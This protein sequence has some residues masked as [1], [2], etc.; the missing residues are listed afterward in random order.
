MND[1]VPTINVLSPLTGETVGT[2]KAMTHEE[3][4]QA[5][6]NAY[7]AF[8]SWK[9]KTILERA[10]IISKAGDILEQKRDQIAASLEQEIGK[11]IETAEKEVDRSIEYLRISV[12]EAKKLKDEVLQGD[13]FKGIKPG[14]KTALI[15]R[16]PV[17][18]VLAISPFNYPVNLAITKI[19]PALL[20]GNSVVFKP[21]TQG[22]LAASMMV[23]A[24]TEAGLPSSLL[25]LITGKSSEIGD[26][27]VTQPT[28]S[29]IAFTGSPKVG[30]RIVELTKGR[31]PLLMEMGGKDP[32]IILSD[33]DLELAS[34]EVV[35]GAFS[36]AGQRCTA[37]KMV[38]VEAP[39]AQEFINKVVEKAKAFTVGPVISVEQKD[40]LL[41]LIEDAKQKGANVA[42]EGSVNGNVLSPTILTNVATTAG[43]FHEEQFGPVLP[44]NTILDINDA[45]NWVNSSQYGLQADVF[46][47]DENKA[48]EIANKLD[49]GTVQINGQSQRY[50]DNFPFLGVRASGIGPAQSTKDTLIA[51]TRAKVIVTNRKV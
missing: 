11:D 27:M 26:F 25:D 2:V 40:F 47:K 39:I 49:V 31:I 42:L 21:A 41:E 12:E 33:A 51:M 44:I 17:G 23:S 32:A 3:V 8:Q 1:S 45:I 43:L 5:I 48:M 22:A 50:P 6:E 16:V 30:F 13:E 18:V 15:K 9:D 19:V 36:Y 4:A 20:M 14:E 7:Q 34:D 28:I 37:V 10:E 24:F 29:L 35:K 46:T 38:F